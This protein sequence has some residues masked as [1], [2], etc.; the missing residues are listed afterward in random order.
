MRLKIFIKTVDRMVSILRILLGISLLF[1]LS[2]LFINVFLRT[3][4]DTS[5]IWAEPVTIY[6]IIWIVFLG[7]GLVFSG[8]EHL[9]LGLLYD[10]VPECWKTVLDRLNQCL[11]VVVSLFLI[12]FGFQLTVDLYLLGQRS[13][14]GLI[15][16]YLVMASIPIGAVVT[17]LT[18]FN[19][20]LKTRVIKESD[21]GSGG[22]ET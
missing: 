21:H 14:D 6:L 10:F 11:T 5:I 16:L 20:T 22:R 1:T 13:Q 12:Y 18:M 2:L 15:P 19:E 17:I 4:T 7:T 3:F 9:T 8:D